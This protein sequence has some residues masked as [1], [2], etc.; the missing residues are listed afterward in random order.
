MAGTIKEIAR[1]ANVSRGTVDRALNDRPGVN[2]EVAQRIKEIARAMDYKPNS[3]AKA[4]ATRNRQFVIGVLINSI[5]NP[6]FDDVILG[7]EAAGQEIEDFGFQLKM[8]KMRGYNAK[9]QLALIK[10]F[11]NEGIDAFAITPVS[12]PMVRDALNEMIADGIHIVCFN[13]DLAGVNYLAYVGCDYYKSGE[14]LGGMIGY[15]TGGKA[16][17]GVIACTNNLEGH[18]M[19]VE[20]CQRVLEKEFP[21]SE[22]VEVIEA[23]DNDEI[24]YQKTLRMLE[25]RKEINALCFNAG[26]TRGGLQAVR[27]LGL[28]KKLDIFTFDLTPAVIEG[29]QNGIVKSTVCQ[30]PF[31]QGYQSIK[32]L[33]D[34]VLN[35]AIP[36]SDHLYTDLSVKIKYNL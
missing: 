13:L 15:I 29:I 24:A 11:V 19:R 18:R 17:L 1:I 10:T 28:E 3:V 26:G 4:L 36:E 14:T 27:D 16:R 31:T 5:G 2:K 6:F 9:E 8:R 33:F 20:G 30:Q 23:E 7:I 25:E 32:I 35:D 22:I 12:D 21:Q 34:A